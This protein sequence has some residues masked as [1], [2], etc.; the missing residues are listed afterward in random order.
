MALTLE[1]SPA[2]DTIYCATEPIIFHLSSTNTGNTGFRFK[3]RVN[4]V[5]DPTYLIDL[6]VPTN[7]NQCGIIDVSQ[8]CKDTLYYDTDHLNT[9]WG[10]VASHGDVFSVQLSARWLDA[11]GDEQT[12]SIAAL[13]YF[14]AVL[15]GPPMLAKVDIDVTSGEQNST[16][17]SFIPARDKFWS[18]LTGELALWSNQ[19]HLTQWPTATAAQLAKVPSLG[20]R[21]GSQRQ[22]TSNVI[23]HHQGKSYLT[24]TV[25]NSLDLNR[26]T[27]NFFVL[28]YDD[29][30]AD[31]GSLTKSL[32]NGS[33]MGTGAGHAAGAKPFR[34]VG[35]GYEQLLTEGGQF[36][37]VLTNAAYYSVSWHTS[38]APITQANQVGPTMLIKLDDPG[39]FYGAP[40]TILY[41]DRGGSWN[42]HDFNGDRETTT[43]I[44][45]QTT[46]EPY[47]GNYT[48]VSTSTDFRIR[49]TDR[50]TRVIDTQYSRT[51]T[52]T[53]AYL[54]DE[55][56]WL[57]E[58]L[59]ASANIYL[60][61]QGGYTTNTPI[62]LLCNDRR[63][64][65]TNKRKDGL[66]KVTMSFTIAQKQKG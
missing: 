51:I 58:D 3:A 62:R 48:D 20:N 47:L 14:H 19:R 21:S 29:D 40:L 12:E 45:K 49:S 66:V 50:G 54:N 18:E 35:I 53:S 33:G 36:A 65:R 63:L 52:L 31:I 7:D 64:S 27:P 4:R 38:A 25:P 15:C 34:N 44:T 60:T 9:P 6:S 37:S 26:Q 28:L 13:S 11:D 2:L 5:G 46:Y 41:T 24:V 10:T 23:Y 1:S 56:Q 61:G 22:L 43:R 42:A 16:W 30:G 39:C 57:Y 17:Q 32:A 8:V 55:E 59:M